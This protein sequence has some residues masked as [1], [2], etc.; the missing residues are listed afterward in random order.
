[1]RSLILI[2]VGLVSFTCSNARAYI[3]VE[4]IPA[5]THSI[6]NEIRN[7]AQY[8]QQTL[9]QFT[10][11]ENQ[12][13]MIFNQG[14]QLVNQATALARFGDQRY[15]VNLLD[16]NGLAATASTLT[17]GV[18]RTVAEFRQA[19]SGVE[20]LG[21][22][23]NGLYSNLTGT[24]DRFGNAV[25]YDANGFRKFGAV[26]DM[27]NAYGQETA[28]YNREMAEQERQLM[29]TTQNFNAASTQMDAT[30]YAGQIEV[31]KA[32]ITALG[33]RLNAVGQRVV[34]QQ[35]ANQNDAAR[36][37]EAQRQQEIQER[38]ADL[39]NYTNWA[40]NYIGGGSN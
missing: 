25:Q 4:D 11:I 29:T 38:E 10:Q 5:L 6:L 12:N 19:A 30:K 32:H 36:V 34:V 14:K 7:Y 24:L 20:A 39:Q 27:Y 2:S 9:N 16:L 31:I 13:T 23:A 8:V 1:M 18:G 22:T 3:L 40:G 28:T 26:N 35:A 21:Y 33:D 17:N 15:Y 37:Q